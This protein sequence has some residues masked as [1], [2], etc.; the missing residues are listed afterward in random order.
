MDMQGV[1]LVFAETPSQTSPTITASENTNIKAE[2][3]TQ[4]DKEEMV[5]HFQPDSQLTTEKISAHLNQSGHQKT[6]NLTKVASDLY[7]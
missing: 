4:L 6:L 1:S 2:Y 3:H 7:E 5:L